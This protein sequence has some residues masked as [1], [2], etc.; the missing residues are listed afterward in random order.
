MINKYA[1]PMSYLSYFMKNC[2]EYIPVSKLAHKKILIVG[3]GHGQDC[4]PFTEGNEIHGL[5]ICENIGCNFTHPKVSYYRESAESMLRESNYYDLVFSVATLEHISNLE[6][7]FSEILRVT[8][9]GGLIYC[10]AAPLWNSYEGHH[11]YGLFSEFPWIHLRLSQPE[12]LKYIQ[13]YKNIAELQPWL[14]LL[15]QEN[16]ISV[17]LSRGDIISYAENVTNFLFSSYFNQ[18]PATQY[19]Q[20]AETLDV[21]YVIRNDIWQDGENFL[22]PDILEELTQKGLNQ[23]ELLSVSHTY[24]AIK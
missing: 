17:P 18:L 2:L 9:P 3:C 19:I 23:E 6:T 16:L 13:A 22:T 20:A 5:D 7:A 15:Q 14:D 11:Y 8:K 24:V 4:E 21:S 10:V 12:L 1:N